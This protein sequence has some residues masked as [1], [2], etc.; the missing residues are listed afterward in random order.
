MPRPSQAAEEERVPAASAK[1]N[2]AGGGTTC[3]PWAPRHY[4]LQIHSSP[5]RQIARAVWMQAVAWPADA[6]V[7][8]KLRAKA[9][10]GGIAGRSVEIDDAVE[11]VAGPDE[12]VDRLTPGVDVGT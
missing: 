3:L 9:S 8:L 5:H 2:E 6:A 7:R 1:Y 12:R 10:G 4:Q 11:E